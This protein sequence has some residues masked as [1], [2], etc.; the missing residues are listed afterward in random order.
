MD[1]TRA[2]Y[3]I[4]QRNKLGSFT[5]WEQVK[6]VPG[7]EDKMVENLRNAGLTIGTGSR[8]DEMSGADGRRENSR[9]GRGFD[10]NSASAED[11]D[12]VF[13]IDG[14]R[15]SYLL[16]ARKRLGKF[17]SWEQVKSEVPSFDDGM[18]ENL[19]K[20]GARLS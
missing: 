3:L 16:D 17:T 15:A 10:L 14:E 12:R 8:G 19:K 18:I 9:S 5:S 13:Q 20:S 7:F 4:E 11:L 2:R 6:Q 1:G